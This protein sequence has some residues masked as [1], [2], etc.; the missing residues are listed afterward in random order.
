MAANII[1]GFRLPKS[2]M[3]INFSGGEIHS[4]HGIYTMLQYTSIWITLIVSLPL[5]ESYFVLA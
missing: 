4:G 5:S 2:G 3:V 1:D